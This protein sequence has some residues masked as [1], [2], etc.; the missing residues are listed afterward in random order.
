MNTRYLGLSL[1]AVSL[2]TPACVKANALTP[3]PQTAA[4]QDRDRD[5]WG[6]PPAEY[7][8]TQRRGYQDGVE[9]A[10]WDFDAHHKTDAD[11]H[12]TYRHPPVEEASRN[13][14]REGF[15][16]GYK[17]AMDHL[18]RDHDYHQ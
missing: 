9:A 16:E 11:D 15:R 14:Y 2:A 12:D 7:R 4:S 10:R 6:V 17:R 8:E 18:R 13:E 3:P 5:R 1:L